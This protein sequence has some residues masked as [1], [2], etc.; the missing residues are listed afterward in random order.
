[1]KLVT[2]VVRDTRD[3]NSYG[4]LSPIGIM[5]RRQAHNLKTEQL[6]SLRST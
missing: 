6:R 3:G 2:V 5:P 1:M 4:C